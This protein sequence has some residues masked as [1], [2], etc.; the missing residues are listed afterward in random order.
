MKQM[1]DTVAFLT[2]YAD[3]YEGRRFAIR[4]TSHMPD[5]ANRRDYWIYTSSP[6]NEYVE[7]WKRY[8]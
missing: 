6:A 1:E 5:I 3:V 2:D 8:S 4:A 7:T